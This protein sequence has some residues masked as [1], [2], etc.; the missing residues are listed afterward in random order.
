MERF[1]SF[2]GL[3]LAYSVTGAEAAGESVLLHHGFASS[4]RVNWERPGVVAAL[5][6][7]G[8]RVVVFD[9]R[10]HGD[11][12]APHDPAAYAGGAMARDVVALFDHLGLERVDMA[13]YSMGA[14][15]TIELAGKA[16]E[17]RLR[18]LFLGGIGT[19]QLLG[20]RPPTETIA[21]ALEAEDA[22]SVAD[23][24]G[25]AF[26]YFAD[27]TGQDRLALAAVQRAG[28]GVDLELLGGISQP[29]LVVNGQSDT[30]A[31]DPADVAALI[32][33]ARALSVPGDHLSAVMKPEFRQ[34]MLDWARR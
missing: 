7:A 10:G 22:T 29:T 19:A 23:P 1:S 21:A 3:S 6:E 11:S 28:R 20:Q 15:V 17:P 9:A 14:F 13:G 5:V 12:E 34:A 33:G 26:R 16:T 31:G 18:S 32:P 8:R 27:A 2:D 30:M 4:A 24:S 25:R